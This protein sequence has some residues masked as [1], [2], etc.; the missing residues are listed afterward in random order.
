VRFDES[1]PERAVLTGPATFVAT[2]EVTAP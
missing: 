2:V 1:R